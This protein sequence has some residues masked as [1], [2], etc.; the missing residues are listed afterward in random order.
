M[1]KTPIQL[2]P[3]VQKAILL[4]HESDYKTIPASYIFG[5]AGYADHPDASSKNLI[6]TMNTFVVKNIVVSE[7]MTL[8][9]YKTDVDCIRRFVWM[10]LGAVL[11]NAQSGVLFGIHGNRMESCFI[12]EGIWGTN[13]EFVADVMAPR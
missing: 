13:R 10:D 2:G 12:T 7:A 3:G 6:L 5:M 1:L 8:R 4:D 11:F 9:D